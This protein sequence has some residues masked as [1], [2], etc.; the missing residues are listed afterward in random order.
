MS[1]L[2]SLLWPV[3]CC[4]ILHN[5]VV[6]RVLRTVAAKEDSRNSRSA[7]LA[8]WIEQASSSILQSTSGI[9]FPTHR[10]ECRNFSDLAPRPT[11][12]PPLPFPL[13]DPRKYHSLISA[14]RKPSSF[15]YALY[16]FFAYASLLSAF[17]PDCCAMGINEVVWCGFQI[18][19]IPCEMEFQEADNR[20]VK[21]KGFTCS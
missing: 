10:S 20:D 18:E 3:S 4:L 16:D 11:L 19:S 17:Y 13:H 12:L 1:F 2:A 7:K 6:L 14:I 9:F 8:P 15:H 5:C 21:S